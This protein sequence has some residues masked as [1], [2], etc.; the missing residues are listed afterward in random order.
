MTEITNYPDARHYLVAPRPKSRPKS[1]LC[2]WY[3]A[4][5]LKFCGNYCSRRPSAYHSRC[6]R[7]NLTIRRSH[8]PVIIVM[9][10]ADGS[11]Y[12]KSIWLK[13][14]TKCQEKDVPLRLVLYA[15]RMFNAT[16]RH[17]WNFI[18]RFRPVPDLYGARGD[19]SL[20][21][22]HGGMRYATVVMDMLRYAC[23]VDSPKCCI[24]ITERTI[25]IRTPVT[26]YKQA[27]SYGDKCVLDPSY[28]VRFSGD[29]LPLPRRR[30]NMEFGLVN[31]R[32]QGLLSCKFLQEA[33]PTLRPYCRYFGLGWDRQERVYSVTNRDLFEKWTQYVGANPDEF[34]LLNSYLIYLHNERSVRRPISVLKQHMY[35]LPAN[36]NTII[37]E[38]H[39]YRD[40]VKRSAVFR[41]MLGVTN[42]E[43]AEN[44]AKR[45]YA[46]MRGNDDGG[47]VISTHLYRILRFLRKHKKRVLFFRSV[48]LDELARV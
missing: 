29:I 41:S 24:L 11:I 6:W 1:N 2:T 47:R 30:G 34:W 40:N 48:Q 38:I 5:K 12:N 26:V 14:I 21:N 42:I 22:A 4:D 18:S 3:F 39:E 23:N 32:G 36:D 46:G 8:R 15:E 16:V 27:A 37:S 28:N 7:H 31:C 13:F 33:L 43:P 44:Y 9:I 35:N 17:P 45:Y 20:I 10:T 25:P 19:I